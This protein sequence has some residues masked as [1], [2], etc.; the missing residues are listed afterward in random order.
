MGW[1]VLESEILDE[2]RREHSLLPPWPL[3]S[4]ASSASLPNTLL[5]TFASEG[6]NTPHA[7]SL[8]GDVLQLLQ[9]LELCAVAESAV[10]SSVGKGQPGKGQLRTPC[11]WAGLY[12]RSWAQGL[13]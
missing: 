1:H 4:L 6:D 2:E 13:Y 5:A 12:G 3:L 9:K 10:G 11:S 8:A 7:L